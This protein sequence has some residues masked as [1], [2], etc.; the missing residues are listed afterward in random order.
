MQ[1]YLNRKVFNDEIDYTMIIR[2]KDN[3]LLMGDFT[4]VFILRKRDKIVLKI[5]KIFRILQF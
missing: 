2:V 4:C 3:I 1:I 5:F